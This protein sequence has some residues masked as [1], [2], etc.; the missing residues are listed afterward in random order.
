MVYNLAY[1]LFS[2]CSILFMLISQPFW[3]AYTDAWA[4]NEID[5]IRHTV[6]KV[7][8]LWF[9]ITTLGLII[10][11]VSPFIYSVWV[12]DAVSVPFSIETR[13]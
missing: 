5:W 1:K 8:Y 6:K 12:N 10:L 2:V 11:S 13:G 9:G 7:H 4:K 3:T